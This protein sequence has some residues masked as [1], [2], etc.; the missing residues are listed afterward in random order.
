MCR[1]AKRASGPRAPPVAALTYDFT[2][3]LEFN[4]QDTSMN[5]CFGEPAPFAR[6]FLFSAPLAAEGI[7]WIHA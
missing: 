2:D 4:E 1:D 7:M 5:T 3:I 6:Y